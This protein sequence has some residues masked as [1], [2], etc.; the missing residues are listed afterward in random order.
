MFFP[1]QRLHWDLYFCRAVQDWELEILTSFLKLIYSMPLTSEEHEK[2][3]WKPEKNK[4][5]KVSEYYLSLSLTPETFFPRKHVW[6][7][8]I[9]PRVAFF[10]WTA[11]LDE[12]LTLAFFSL[13][14]C[15]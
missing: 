15:F 13:P 14:H 8:K 6:C 3:C 10:S 12:I 2:L 4:G 9:P 1:N 7:S 11:A 5:F